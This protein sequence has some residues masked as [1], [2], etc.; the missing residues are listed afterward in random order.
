MKNYKKHILFLD[1]KQAYDKKEKLT[2]NHIG[3]TP[4]LNTL[5]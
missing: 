2:G 4:I 3:K 1:Y 5:A